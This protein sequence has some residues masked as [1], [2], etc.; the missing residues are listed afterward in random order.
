MHTQKERSIML[1]TKVSDMASGRKKEL[2]VENKTAA[3]E[4]RKQHPTL[5]GET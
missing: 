2:D 5:Q 4:E 1:K 3:K